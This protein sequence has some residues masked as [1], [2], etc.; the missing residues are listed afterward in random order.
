MASTVDACSLALSHIGGYTI[1][2]LDDPTK[3]ARECKRLAIP[4]RDAT[5]EAGDWGF[6]RKSVALALLSYT[7]PGWSY[8]YAWPSD[9][10]MPRRIYDPSREGADVDPATLDSLGDDPIPFEVGVNDALNARI[11]LTNQVSAIVVYTARVTDA[12]LFSPTFID[13]WSWRLAADL[14]IPIRSDSALQQKMLAQFERRIGQA[15]QNS[16][17]AEYRKPNPV[18]SYKRAR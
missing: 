3:E 14:A 2:S 11:I 12:N 15:G 4:A 1:Q 16:A 8:A 7:R 10:L 5:L 17:N 18:S 9:C 13:A 6:A